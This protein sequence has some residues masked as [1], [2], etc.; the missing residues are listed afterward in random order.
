LAI[1]HPDPICAG[2]KQ[3]IDDY[4]QALLRRFRGQEADLGRFLADDVRWHLPRSA[5]GFASAIDHVGR[6][7]VLD[8]LA[9]DVE[10]FY[11]PETIRFETHSLIAEG[12]RVHLHF[13][14]R[15]TTSSG[16]EY[17]NRYQ[18]L[19]RLADGRIVEAW[20]SLD[21]AYLFGLFQD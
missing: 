5:A 8:M 4:M 18:T 14:M 7:A 21:T 1:P 15:A 13:S 9:G 17:D 19:F 11:L 10:K 20:E 2:N 12:D 6:Q 16:R 3:R